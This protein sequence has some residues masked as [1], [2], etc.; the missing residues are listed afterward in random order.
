[1]GNAIIYIGEMR[2]SQILI[3]K[4]IKKVLKQDS[5]DKK[6]MELITL[7]YAMLSGIE[8]SIALHVKR[9]IDAGATRR[10]VLNVI[11]CII[12]DKQL[13]SSILEVFKASNLHF[14]K[15]KYKK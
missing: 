11:S 4:D 8:H 5:N 13:F 7:A 1:M 15:P 10:D 12:G 6:T 14:E 3:Y 2:E 9:A